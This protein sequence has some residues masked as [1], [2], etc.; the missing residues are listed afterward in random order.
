MGVVYMS[1]GLVRS[2]IHLFRSED[3][4]EYEESLDADESE[5]AI[6]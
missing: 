3:V 2:A 1:F 5:E 6:A 4:D